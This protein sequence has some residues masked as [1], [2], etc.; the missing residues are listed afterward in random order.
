[1][2]RPQDD[3][4]KPEVAKL[5]AEMLAKVHKMHPLSTN[6]GEEQG[7]DSGLWN[8]MREW[9]ELAPGGP[10]GFECPQKR[11]MASMAH[12]GTMTTKAVLEQGP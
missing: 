8:K 11:E 5:I 12:K 2:T 10:D 3:V 1:M 6:K 9:L 4:R 7:R